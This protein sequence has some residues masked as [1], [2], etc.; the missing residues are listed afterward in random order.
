MAEFAKVVKAARLKRRLTQ[1]DIAVALSYSTTSFVNKVEK[2]SCG[3]RP[4]SLKAWAKV[5]RVPVKV[6]VAAKVAD[7]QAK[8]LSSLT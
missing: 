3:V 7:Y 1:G 5:L 2:G 4:Q 8:V 6:L